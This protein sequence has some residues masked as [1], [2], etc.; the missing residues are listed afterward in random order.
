MA[1]H[2]VGQ[3]QHA[4]ARAI[5]H[6]ARL[7][8][9]GLLVGHPR[10]A[11]KA[12]PRV[13]VPG[14]VEI[15]VFPGEVRPAARV[16][17]RRVG[18][19]EDPPPL[20]RAGRVVPVDRRRGRKEEVGGARVHLVKVD[21]HVRHRGEI[22]REARARLRLHAP[23][24]VPVQV[25]VPVVRP[26][27]RPRRP[28]LAGLRVGIGN[29]S[30][31]RAEPRGVALVTVRIEERVDDHHRPIEPFGDRRVLRRGQVVDAA[32]APPPSTTPR[33]RGPRTRARRR[34]AGPPPAPGSPRRPPGSGAGGS[35]AARGFRPR[36]PRRATDPAPRP[37]ARSSPAVSGR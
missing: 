24:P 26:A 3:G 34:S 1:R 30:R 2:A 6:H 33:L 18:L 9:A 12:R 11:E 4:V 7:P 35:R 28:V 32:R 8:A 14:V 31:D 27:G 15:E 20:P 19:P 16:E 5:E 29:G 23:R 21:V 37:T 17:R 10:G 22:D 13:A 25:R 36:R